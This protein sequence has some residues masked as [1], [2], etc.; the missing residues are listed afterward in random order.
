ME[1]G[2]L[3]STKKILGLD[4]GYTAF[5]QDVITHIN[6]CFSILHQIGVG[7][8]DGFMIEDDG[9]EWED[10][11]QNESGNHSILNL[12]RT[13]VFLRVKMLF[14]PPTTSFHIDAMNKQIDEYETRISYFR[15][16]AVWT[17]ANPTV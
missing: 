10:Y 4:S 7:P 8:A 17:A 2:I 16:E 14:D 1:N 12:I 6:S 11:I 15:E 3:V 9:P 13:Y 5:D